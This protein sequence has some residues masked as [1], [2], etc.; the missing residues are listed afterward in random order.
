MEA[1]VQDSYHL[2][3]QNR[4]KLMDTENRLTA[5]RKIGRLGEIGDRIKKSKN[6]KPPHRHR[7]HGEYQKGRWGGGG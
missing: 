5:V 6:K 2:N 4:N 1:G 3:K 7:H